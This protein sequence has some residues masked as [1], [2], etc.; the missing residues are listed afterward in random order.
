MFFEMIS[1][2]LSILPSKVCGAT[3]TRWRS[4]GPQQHIPG[5][6]QFPSKTTRPTGSTLCIIVE[7]SNFIRQMH[8]TIK[9]STYKTGV[10]TAVMVKGAVGTGNGVAQH[11]NHEELE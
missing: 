5:S 2:N 7:K 3:T 10:M 9:S 1:A 4:I 6:S 11:H 8:I